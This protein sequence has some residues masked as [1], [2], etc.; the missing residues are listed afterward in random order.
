MTFEMVEE[1]IIS[2]A[3][4]VKKLQITMKPT[5]VM[6]EENRLK[7]FVAFESV[8]NDASKKLKNVSF[9]RI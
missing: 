5:E 9:I 2:A 3:S 4:S 1:I 6:N 7:I 8:G